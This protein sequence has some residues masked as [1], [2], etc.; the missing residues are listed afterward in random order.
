[1][2][3]ASVFLPFDW[4]RC[5]P[6]TSLAR[7]AAC[8][9]ARLGRSQ[10]ASMPRAVRLDDVHFVYSLLGEDPEAFSVLHTHPA[11]AVSLLSVHAPY[12]A[13]E[14][15]GARLGYIGT[16]SLSETD[17]INGYFDHCRSGVPALQATLGVPPWADSLVAER[18]TAQSS[19]L[20]RM[21]CPSQ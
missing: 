11:N 14:Q 18:S 16:V 20:A 10:C 8:S 7:T 21:E 3:N 15:F 12:H 6:R 9:K 1:M 4:R 17:P 19:R 2:S 5:C 13:S